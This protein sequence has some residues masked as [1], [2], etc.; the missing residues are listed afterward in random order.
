MP[1]ASFL[2][3]FSSSSCKSPHSE[4]RQS[5]RRSSQPWSDTRSKANPKT[6]SERRE[7]LVRQ[8]VSSTNQT[9]K[10][11]TLTGSRKCHQA[12]ARGIHDARD[13]L[14]RSQVWDTERD[15]RKEKKSQT[16]QENNTTTT[17]TCDH[18][19]LDDNSNESLFHVTR[20]T[21]NELTVKKK[22]RS[23]E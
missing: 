12:G 10:R 2:A 22:H 19:H 13:A 18:A 11:G 3:S 6:A 20:T 15:K 9:Q 1:S 17:S 23:Q 21:S 7:N 14:Q 4:E 5:L 8:H 16:Q